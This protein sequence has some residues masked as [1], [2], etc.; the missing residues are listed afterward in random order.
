MVVACGLQW[1]GG[2]H[3]LVGLICFLFELDTAILCHISGMLHR[4]PGN[5]RNESQKTRRLRFYASDGAVCFFPRD[6]VILRIFSSFF[7]LVVPIVQGSFRTPTAS[8][9]TYLEA[10]RPF[11][12]GRMT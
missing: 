12:W 6:L 10:L 3:D 8:C 2:L 4:R 1:E 5:L 11:V 7:F 9:G